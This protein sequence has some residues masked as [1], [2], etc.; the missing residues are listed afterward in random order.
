M[1]GTG[2]ADV[3]DLN[4]SPLPLVE[5]LLPVEGFELMETEESSEVVLCSA[6]GGG[7]ANMGVKALRKSV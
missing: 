4:D 5:K 3:G 7:L 2:Y 1:G 6:V